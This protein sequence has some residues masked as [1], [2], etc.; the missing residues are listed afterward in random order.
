MRQSIEVYSP[1]HGRRIDTKWSELKHKVLPIFG[2]YYGTL[3]ANRK[4]RGDGAKLQK[5]SANLRCKRAY[6]DVAMEAYDALRRIKRG[7]NERF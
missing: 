2:G 3:F 1:F 4:R 7:I 6:G 5:D